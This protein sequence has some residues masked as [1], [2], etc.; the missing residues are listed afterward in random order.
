NPNAFANFIVLQ[1]VN[2]TVYRVQYR[3]DLAS[4]SWNLL[5]DQIIGTGTNIFLADPAAASLAGR[6]YR[7]QVLW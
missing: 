7:A 3:D 6:F 2:G 5:A 4:G 1:S